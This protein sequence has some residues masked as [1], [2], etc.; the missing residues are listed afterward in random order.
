MSAFNTPWFNSQDRSFFNV[1]NK[2]KIAHVILTAE[3]DDFD[4]ETAQKWRD[5]GFHAVYVPML[6]GGNDFIKRLHTVG[7]NFG[8]SEQ[9]AIVA[10][11]DAAHLALEAHTKPNH[12]KLVAIVAYYPSA[13]PSIHTKYPAS[14]Q[15]L[16]H[17]A[18]NEIGVHKHPEVLGIQGKQ[19]TVKKRIDPG[20]GFGECLKLGFRAYTYSGVKS[21]FAEQ[22]LD[23]Y[24]PIADGVAFTRS[25]ACVRKG[26]RVDSDIEMM[27][28]HHVR[29]LHSGQQEK[30]VSQTRPYAHV[31]HAPTLTGG[32]GLED[33]TDFYENF[34]TPIP[35]QTNV[36]IRL[37]SR[38]VGTDRVVDEL[39]V[40]LT[41]TME[42][43]WLLPGV[44]PTNKRIEIAIVSVFHVRGEKLESEHVYWDQASVLVQAGLLDPKVVPDALKKKGVKQLP[45][46]GAEGARAIKRGSSQKINDLI[47][48]W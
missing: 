14:V 29:Y 34:F 19:K 6:K 8:V 46:V 13:I 39:Y 32:I 40:A 21:G 17:L 26:F 38:T 35:R 16:V 37:L 2:S 12:P 33:I 45:V 10:Y 3:T 44:P 18:G 47:P 20:V 23:E 1:L 42:V 11:G 25:I 22:D 5:E 48:D 31:I 30:A 9:Y 36:Q 7:D 24:D 15:V 4:E 41:H 28:D 27:R 43:P